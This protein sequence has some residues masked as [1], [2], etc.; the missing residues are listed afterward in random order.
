MCPVLWEMYSLKRMST[1]SNPPLHV[2]YES[3]FWS[4][5]NYPD[6]RFSASLSLTQAPLPTP[7][8]QIEMF[9]LCPIQ[10]NKLC[11]VKFTKDANDRPSK[12]FT[13][14]SSSIA[15]NT[16]SPSCTATNNGVNLCSLTFC[17]IAWSQAPM[18]REKYANQCS[19]PSLTV[20]CARHRNNVEIYILI[21]S[22]SLPI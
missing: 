21:S 14:S 12:Y 10:R 19:C 7:R 18:N 4:P 13:T 16:Q 2:I 11:A 22:L 9:Y 1:A 15:P 8:M 3:M 5:S 6:L 20:V 17:K